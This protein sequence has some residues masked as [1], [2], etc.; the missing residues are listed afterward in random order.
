MAR[1]E[2]PVIGIDLGTMYSCVGVFQNGHVK[3]IA[4]EHGGRKT[5]SCVAFTDTERL[6]GE[7]VIDQAGMNAANTVFNAKQLIGRKFSDLSVQ[8]DIK[9]WQCKVFSGPLEKPMILVNYKGEEKQFS[10]EEI[11]SM[12]LVRMKEIAEKHLGTTVRNAVITVPAYYNDSQRQAIRDAGTIAGLKV[13]RTIAEPTAAAVAYGFDKK[14]AG[15]V[16][17]DGE[18]NVLIFDLGA[19]NCNVSLLTMEDGIFEV[20]ATHGASQFGGEDFVN[21]MVNHFV[22]EFRRKNNKDISGNAK[23]MRRLKKECEKAKRLLSSV[24]V[25]NIYL[26]YF[27]Y[28]DSFSANITRDD[29]NELNKDLFESCVELVKKCLRDA[30]ID[31]RHIHE[32]VPVGGSSRIPKVQQ[33]LK[34]FFNGKEL[35]MGL[36]TDEGVAYGATVQAAV[37]SGRGDE[38]FQDLMLLDVNPLSLGIDINGEMS[39]IIPKNYNIPAKKFKI[40]PTTTDNQV[41]VFIQVFEGEHKLTKHNKL[42]GKFVFSGI[43]P[44]PSGVSKYIVYFDIDADGL[45]NVSA[46]NEN[47]EPLEEIKVPTYEDR[48]SK[49]ELKKLV[50]EAKKYKADDEENKKKMEAR[51]AVESYFYNLKNIISDERLSSRFGVASRKK[52][53]DA[54]DIENLWSNGNQFVKLENLEEIIKELK[55]LAIF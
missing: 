48:F 42:L 37:L 55:G 28:D 33:L 36:N 31:K 51:I 11:C 52:M 1:G 7:A 13:M 22:E 23:C 46:E 15:I 34:E 18:K 4:S 50:Q 10:A 21:R 44:A 41:A 9:N 6:I 30:R 26:D 19:S 38:R 43:P 53:K 3:I 8:R 24:P 25:T 35:S 32:V 17:S 27:Y 40:F 12:V 20:K 39:V 2:E 29:F 14:L 47:S 5:P 54:I 49:E 45:F 16:S